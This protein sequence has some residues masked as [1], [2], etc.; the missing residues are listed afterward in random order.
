MYQA[1]S[2]AGYRLL[3]CATKYANEELVGQAIQRALDDGVV[4]RDDL[5]IVTKLWMSDFK[6]PEAALRTSLSKL[7]VEQ[8]DMYLIHWP[9]G[10]FDADP[11]N[12]VPIHVLWGKFEALVDAGLT[13]SIGVSN[14]SLQM[15]ADL[16]CY[17]RIKPV[18]N[19]V[20]LNPT[21]I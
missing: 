17:C 9:A 2:E 20:E 21:L 4:T 18:T 6:D 10:F 13:K 1:I 19:E 12:R 14:F 7:Q 11:A 16:L 5:F 8:V 15:L 3:D